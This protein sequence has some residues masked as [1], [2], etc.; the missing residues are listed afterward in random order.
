MRFIA[1]FLAS[2]V[3]MSSTVLMAFSV[4]SFFRGETFRLSFFFFY[5]LLLF[6]IPFALIGC[7]FGEMLIKY[8]PR[9]SLGNFIFYGAFFGALLYIVMNVPNIESE[10][11][12]GLDLFG[13]LLLGGTGAVTSA[14]FYRVRTHR[15]RLFRIG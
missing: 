14:I 6:G 12:L 8:D 3:T 4:I 7:L 9:S 13:I 15:G 2:Y 5:Y 10:A 11:N 1:A